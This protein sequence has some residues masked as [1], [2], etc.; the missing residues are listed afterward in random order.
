MMDLKDISQW[1]STGSPPQTPLIRAFS[2]YLTGQEAAQIFQRFQ[3]NDWIHNGQ[4]L[5]SGVPRDKAQ[6]WAGKHHLQTLTTAMGPLMDEEHPECLKSKMSPHHWSQ[7][8][9][10][11]SAVFA[12][13]I[14]R[15]EKVTVLS[16][17]PPE[18]FHP[19][20]L[21]NYQ[22][23]EE[24]IVRG[25][26]GQ[27]AVRQIVLVHPTVTESEEYLY[28]RWPED[29][30]STWI[31]KF[32][33]R[34][35]KTKWRDVGRSGDKLRLKTLM[36]RPKQYPLAEPIDCV[37][38]AEDQRENST[39]PSLSTGP[40]HIKSGTGQAAS[41]VVLSM[42]FFLLSS[43][44]ALL[45][46]MGLSYSL[47]DKTLRGSEV[48]QSCRLQDN[49]KAG[50][51]VNWAKGANKM[52]Y[53]EPTS[54]RVEFKTQEEPKTKLK[55]GKKVQAKA[56]K[57]VKKNIEVEMKAQVK[58]QE[59]AKRKKLKA[60]LDAQAKMKKKAQAE[61]KSQAKAQEKAKQKELK[62]EL[63]AQAKSKKKAKAER[64]SQDK[65]LEK[66][67]R[68]KLKAELEAQAKMKKKAEAVRKAQA[69]AKEKA[70]SKEKNSKSS[71]Q[72]E[73]RGEGEAQKEE[74]LTSKLEWLLQ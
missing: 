63:E 31:Q 60:E 40:H 52:A 2:Q 35:K 25:Q 4:V 38:K 26:I 46:L 23:I 11:A 24:P 50:Q 17:P 74:S 28:E 56:Q 9:R 42:F 33:L 14:A 13:H 69:K 57:E 6:E 30:Y 48:N 22:A 8:I 5:W 20:G 72:G 37:E 71:S 36:A 1:L 51:E 47:I 61:R 54:D 3:S 39:L 49:P 27:Y 7:Y 16:P 15:G 45:A 34:N 29:K 10:G 44:F 65:A 67:K 19:S 66:A 12:W 32:G 64:K 70:K 21:T 43:R 41:V 55:D 73:R 68:K 58:A 18:R 62:D 59:E 53:W